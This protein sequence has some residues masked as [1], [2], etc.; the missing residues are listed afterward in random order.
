MYSVSR[1]SQKSAKNFTV[2]FYENF[3]IAFII[4]E[5]TEF[6]FSKFNQPANGKPISR[7]LN[8]DNQ[9]QSKVERVILPKQL[10]PLKP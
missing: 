3:V 1:E 6:R 8:F 7:T 5:W 10:P 9:P 2:N 4:N